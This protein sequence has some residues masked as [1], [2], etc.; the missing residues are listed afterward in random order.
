M[1]VRSGHNRTGVAVFP[2]HRTPQLLAGP[3]LVAVAVNVDDVAVV[4]QAVDLEYLRSFGLFG[5]WQL[6][7][8]SGPGDR[9]HF[10]IAAK[11]STS[12]VER[13]NLTMRMQIR[14]LTRLTNGFSKKWENLWAALCLHFAHYNFCRVHRT[15][16]VTP[17]M[18]AGITSHVWMIGELLT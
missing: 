2:L 11:I 5:L 6:W 13:Q 18:Q 8:S 10:M 14:R 15:I 16:R 17:A 1:P 4:Q 12:H 3:H 9:V 7:Q